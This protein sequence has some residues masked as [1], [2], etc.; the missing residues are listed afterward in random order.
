M[1]AF[2]VTAVIDGVPYNVKA[3]PFD[4]NTEKRFRVNY[5]GREYI[6][7]FDSSI[8]KYAAL[9]DD[10]IDLPVNLEELVAEKLESYR[11]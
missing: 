11:D 6:F 1:S 8:G 5:G 2:D 9:G 3:E 7:A 10:S 4:F